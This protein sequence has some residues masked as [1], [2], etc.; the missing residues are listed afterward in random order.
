MTVHRSTGFL[1]F[2]GIL[3]G[4][5]ASTYSFAQEADNQADPAVSARLA[6]EAL[7]LDAETLNGRIVAVGERGHVIL[8]DDGGQTWRQGVVPVR[9]TLTAVDFVDEKNGWAV[10]HDGAI[11]HSNDGGE[12]WTLQNHAPELEQPLLDV[13]FFDAD[14]GIAIGAYG[15]YLFTSDGGG[16]WEEIMIDEEWDYHLNAIVEA[17]DANLYIAAEAGSI[18]RSSDRGRTWTPMVFP[19]EGS[20]FGILDLGSG[21]L[22]TFGLRGNVFESDDHG[23]NWRQVHTGTE[24]A[25]LGGRQLDDGTVV[26]VG[27]S[28]TIL[29]WPPGAHAFDVRRHD[30]G[31]DLVAV[32][33]DGNGG[34]LLFGQ[35]GVLTS[36]DP[37][38]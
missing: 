32:V 23:N 16:T 9:S 26:L 13:M 22:M 2:L 17:G 3:I 8:S 37:G 34:L 6:P 24:R 28:G 36:G 19:Y 5:L 15:Y 31:A 14:D 30:E 20:M 25:L 12:T 33:P 7:L 4:C 29:T 21:R 10:G 35:S 38:E 18:Y 1:A 11:V 27:A